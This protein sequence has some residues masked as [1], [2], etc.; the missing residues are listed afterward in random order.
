[1]DINSKISK[2]IEAENLTPNSFAN[3]IGVKA[4]I[5]YN[6][7]KGRNKPSFDLLTKILITFGVDANWLLSDDS[8]LAPGATNDVIY[9]NKN[10]YLN[11]SNNG[12]L[13]GENEEKAHKNV[14]EYL[15]AVIESKKE[16]RADN[17]EIYYNQNLIGIQSKRLQDLKEKYIRRFNREVAKSDTELLEFSVLIDNL[18]DLI[19][20]V[21]EAYTN[22]LNNRPDPFETSQYFDFQKNEFAFPETIDYNGYKQKTME[23]L[24][25]A[26]Q[27]ENTVTDFYKQLERFLE[28]I[29]PLD[30]AN[31]N[32]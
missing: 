30:Q 29:E 11:S 15:T 25:K 13:N 20:L 8:K 32:K 7:Q 24:K 22:T 26:K 23:F 9:N 5:I 18:G 4:T 14:N 1:M 27:Y 17:L 19:D 10:D 3:K 31:N 28:A 2:I 16:E 6:I 12:Y 21:S